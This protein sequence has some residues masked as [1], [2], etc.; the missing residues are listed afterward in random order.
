[1]NSLQGRIS[2]LDIFRGICA[3]MVFIYHLAA[4]MRYQA[5]MPKGSWQAATYEFAWSMLQPLSTFA[6]IGFFVLSGFVITLYIQ[7]D[8]AREGKYLEFLIFRFTRFSFVCAPAALVSVA[9]AY[10]YQTTFPGALNRPRFAGGWF[11]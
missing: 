7:R 8:I 10:I 6:V 1:M 4:H 3:L 9:L 11:I 5:F 2:N